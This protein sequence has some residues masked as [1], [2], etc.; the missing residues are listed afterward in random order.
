MY[1]TTNTTLFFFIF[2][3]NISHPVSTLLYCY[4]AFT[5]CW[6]WLVLRELIVTTLTGSYTWS[7]LFL[8]PL[9]WLLL[10]AVVVWLL[11]GFPFANERLCYSKGMAVELSCGVGL[12]SIIVGIGLR[13]YSQPNGILTTNCQVQSNGVIKG[14]FG[15]SC[16]SANWKEIIR[17]KPNYIWIQIESFSGV[18]TL[19]HVVLLCCTYRKGILLFMWDW[20]VRCLQTV[21]A[22]AA[23]HLYYSWRI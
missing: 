22:H 1:F 7:H 18:V 21:I 2:L 19:I 12:W 10:F 23:L 15:Q 11:C 14:T 5:V 8:F 3:H 4:S 6:T 13:L 17:A 20:K 16:D 9:I